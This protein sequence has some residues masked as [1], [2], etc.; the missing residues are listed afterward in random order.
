M[1]DIWKRLLT[2]AYR[3][4]M[5]LKVSVSPLYGLLKTKF[6]AIKV[7]PKCSLTF[8]CFGGN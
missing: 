1:E 6:P 3:N 8:V 4:W 5:K 2:I 7:D